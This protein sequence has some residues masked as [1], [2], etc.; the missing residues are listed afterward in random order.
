LRLINSHKS[1]INSYENW[2]FQTVVLEKTLESPLGCKEIK[3]VYPKGFINYQ[4][5]ININLSI[6][7]ISNYQSKYWLGCKEIEP[8]DHKSSI[9]MRIDA[10]KLWCWRRLLRV[11]WAVRRSNQLILKEIN[12]TIHWKK[13]CSSWNSSTLATWCQELTHWKER[14]WC[15]ERKKA[16]EEV[17]SREW[18]V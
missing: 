1:L 9:L 12:L 2:C 5:I 18:N 13:W 8:V 7:K 6:I 14:P 16:K 11:P 17:G 3:P 4:F 15:W 10:F